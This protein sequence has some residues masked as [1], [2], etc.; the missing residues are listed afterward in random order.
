M[1]RYLPIVRLL[2]LE[3]ED[4]VDRLAHDF[5]ASFVASRVILLTDA[6]IGSMHPTKVKG[7]GHLSPLRP[8]FACS[9]LVLP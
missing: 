7:I 1:N 2:T 4:V 5:N 3:G 8:M 6:I 9:V